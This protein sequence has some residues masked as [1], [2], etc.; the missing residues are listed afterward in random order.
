MADIEILHV[1][2]LSR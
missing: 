2:C 1:T